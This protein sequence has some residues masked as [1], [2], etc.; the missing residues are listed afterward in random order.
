[1]FLDDVF[2][3]GGKIVA[4]RVYK[5]VRGNWLGKFLLKMGIPLCRLIGQMRIRRL[6]EV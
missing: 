4:S 2:G 5:N 6:V 1:M 3:D